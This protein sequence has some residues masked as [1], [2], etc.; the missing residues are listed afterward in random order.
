VTET[1]TAIG[2]SEPA[3]EIAGIA[4][5]GCLL[6]EFLEWLMVNASAQSVKTYRSAL[7]DFIRRMAIR[8]LR[9]VTGEVIDRY[10]GRLF[11]A[12]L[13]ESTR[14]MRGQSAPRKFFRWLARRGYVAVDPT[15]D[16]EPMQVRFMERIPIL[17][18]AE[19]ARLTFRCPPAPEPRKGRREPPKFFLRRFELHNLVDLRDRALLA[20]VFDIPLRGGEPAL[21]ERRDYD[22]SRGEVDI[23]GAK[24]QSEP[25]SFPVLESTKVAMALYLAALR[26]SRWSEHPALFPPLGIRR[27]DTKRPAGGIGYYEVYR[28]LKRRIE[29]AGIQARGRRLSPHVFRYSR[30]THWKEEGVSLEDI[31]ALLRHSKI[32]TTRRYLRLGP[33]KRVKR[34]ADRASLFRRVNFEIPQE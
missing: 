10:R 29:R 9:A 15:K 31:S 27:A 7:Q 28:I 3:L 4:E 24:W 18:R 23:R 13:S 33:L 11:L 2:P 22:E 30:A 26:Q 17:T 21:L 12:G 19:I 34:R 8:D 25:V 1:A 20:L 6:E 5:P 32:E 14:Q 16:L